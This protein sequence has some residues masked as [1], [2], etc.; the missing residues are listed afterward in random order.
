[1]HRGIFIDHSLP[2]FVT[3][4]WY[5]CWKNMKKIAK[6]A[7][8]WNI[9]GGLNYLLE[10]QRFIKRWIM[11]CVLIFLGTSA[12]RVIQVICFVA[13]NSSLPKE[14]EV[15]SFEDVRA[16]AIEKVQICWI[17]YYYS[18]WLKLSNI[19]IYLPLGEKTAI[20][21]R[22]IYFLKTSNHLNKLLNKVSIFNQ[23]G[24]EVTCDLV[25]IDQSLRRVACF[26]KTFYNIYFLQLNR[27]RLSV[28]LLI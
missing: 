22:E 26:Y 8:F 1:M 14:Y 21:R 3:C 23:D 16:K 5:I 2:M 15:L 6:Y 24:C 4:H 20:S 11:Y 17:M 12:T 27:A 18:T 19:S 25:M 7:L 13:V 10:V 9:Q 28:Q